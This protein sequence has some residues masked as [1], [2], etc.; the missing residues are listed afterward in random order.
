M[1]LKRL[2]L[3][4]AMLPSAA[5]A[6]EV[7]QVTLEEWSQPRAGEAMTH[8]PALREA[9]HALLEVESGE[10]LLRYPGGDRGVLWA[11]ELRAWL[12]ALGLE[13]QRIAM[14]PGSVAAD[15]IELNLIANSGSVPIDKPKEKM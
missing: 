5:L 10:L 2:F 11:H 9:L 6:D 13:S 15:T 12:I 14:Q 4:V 1:M 3:I 8:L 7:W